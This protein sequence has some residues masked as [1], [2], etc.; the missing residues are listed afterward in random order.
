MAGLTI[1]MDGLMYGGGSGDQEQ[2]GLRSYKPVLGN[3]NRSI[4]SKKGEDATFRRRACDYNL[5]VSVWLPVNLM[6]LHGIRFEMPK[7]K[8]E[9]SEEVASV[10]KSLTYDSHL[11]RTKLTSGTEKKIDHFGPS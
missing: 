9:D 5:E 4:T 2:R 3:E 6:V 8:E 11:I 1:C 7:E 10:F